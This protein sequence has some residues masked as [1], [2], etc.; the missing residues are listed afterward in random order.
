MQYTHPTNGKSAVFTILVA[1]LVAGTLD[2]LAAC[3]QFYINT[4]KGPERIFQFIASGIYGKA[5]F[6]GGSSVAISGLLL[7][8]LIAFLFAAFYVWL[9]KR[10]KFLHGNP[11][12]IGIIYGIFV[13]VIMNRVVLPLSK[14]PAIPFDLQKAA[15]AMG[16]LILMIGIPIAAITNKLYGGKGR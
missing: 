6:S 11:V 12:P 13:W 15:I 5:A 2:I 14:A 16:I 4:G 10:W 3:V 8:Y 7:H 9:Y 1:G